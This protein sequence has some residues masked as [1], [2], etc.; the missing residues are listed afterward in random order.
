MGMRTLGRTGRDVSALGM[1][2]WAIGGPWSSEDGRPMGWSQ[3]DDSESIRAIH[4]ALDLGVTFFDTAANYGCGHSER[5]L[6]KALGDRRKGVSIATKFGHI[7]D[8]EKKFIRGDNE[9]IVENLPKDCEASL[10]RLGTDVID[11][12]QLHESP[13]EEAKALEVRDALEELVAEGKIRAYGWSTDHVD[14]AKVF[15][16]GK[17][18]A[19]IQFSLNAFTDNAEMIALCERESLA[20]INKKPLASGFLTGKFT[21]QTTFPEDDYRRVVD[22]SNPRFAGML[23]MADALRD[24]LC[25]GGRTMVQGALAWIW[26]RS[27]ITIPIPGFKTVDQVHENAGALRFGPFSTE[28][29]KEIDRIVEE[30]RSRASN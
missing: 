15:A 9:R 30:I 22:F 24:A 18:C 11:L 17:H 29:A 26:A 19:T 4:E 10:R 21:S 6:G 1:G 25:T 13:L 27:E 2:C 14:C 20:G 5:I 16:G 3:V 28:E 8:E 23:E 7:I 12:Y